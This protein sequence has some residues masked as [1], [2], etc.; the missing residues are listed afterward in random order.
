MMR[1]VVGSSTA[2]VD[3]QLAADLVALGWTF[4]LNSS[5]GSTPDWSL[6]NPPG[7]VWTPT[8]D[9][10]DTT[11]VSYRNAAV[12]GLPRA[13]RTC[14]MGFEAKL[15]AVYTNLPPSGY[16]INAPP[17][18]DFSAVE[19]LRDQLIIAL[20]KT[21]TGFYNISGGEWVNMNGPA[22]GG[23]ELQLGR[24][25]TLTLEIAR[26]VCDLVSI[27]RAQTLTSIDPVTRILVT[28]KGETT[29]T[30]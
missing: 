24:A 1:D 29:D 12:D 15:W 10:F 27:G 20:Q 9:R 21:V 19:I 4:P 17:L 25:Y 6:T 18:E 11:V 30:P 23:E 2:L 22:Q 8:R 16:F 28:P 26:P 3:A 5:L 14:W 13:V 7:I